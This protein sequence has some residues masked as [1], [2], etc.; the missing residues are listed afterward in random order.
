MANLRFG[1]VL[2]ADGGALKKMLLPFRMGA[3]GIVGNGR[4]F[5]SWVA[6]EDVIGAIQCIL[7]TER[8]TVRSM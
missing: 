5:W 1:I 8:H 3:G 2:S 6:I 7:K 4:Q